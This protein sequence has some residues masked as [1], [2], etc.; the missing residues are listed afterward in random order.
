M[1]GFRLTVSA[2]GESASSCDQRQ[3]RKLNFSLRR[4]LILNTER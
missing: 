2:T 4:L 3:L 1:G